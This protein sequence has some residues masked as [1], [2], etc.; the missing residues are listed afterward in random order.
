ME[1]RVRWL[2]LNAISAA[3]GTC[4]LATAAVTLR[5]CVCS[6]RLRPCWALR[7]SAST[8]PCYKRPCRCVGIACSVY[9]VEVLNTGLSWCLQRSRRCRVL[10][11][12]LRIHIVV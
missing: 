7:H 4:L 10:L 8:P 2:R 11:E 6:C 12:A 9:S 3:P 1:W 5:L